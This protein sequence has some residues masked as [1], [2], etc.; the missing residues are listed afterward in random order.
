VAQ[1]ID[2]KPSDDAGSAMSKP[3]SFLERARLARGKQQPPSEQKKSTANNSM[4]ELN[5]I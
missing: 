2:G 1:S 3:L 5:T 4:E